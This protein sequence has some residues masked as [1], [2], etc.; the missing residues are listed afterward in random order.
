MTIKPSIEFDV[1]ET[2][3]SG[4]FN[5]KIIIAPPRLRRCT[6][7]TLTDAQ[8]QSIERDNAN[9]S[10]FARELVIS[11]LS[12]TLPELTLRQQQ[13]QQQQSSVVPASSSSSSTTI[14]ATSPEPPSGCA[15]AIAKKSMA[16]TTLQEGKRDGNK[17][18]LQ[19]SS[20]QHQTQS[21]ITTDNVNVPIQNQG[22]ASNPIVQTLMHNVLPQSL[23]SLLFI[24]YCTT[25]EEYVCFPVL[26]TISFS[27]VVRNATKMPTF[28]VSF[29]NKDEKFAFTD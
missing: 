1:D 12:Q 11:T 27:I 24:I 18:T 29:V 20:Q 25:W 5:M 6:T 22:L 14:T 9:K 28:L 15:N 17:S 3:N 13:Q 26:H 16:S 10:L 2:F 19:M 7:T 4:L 8:L 23:V 21:T